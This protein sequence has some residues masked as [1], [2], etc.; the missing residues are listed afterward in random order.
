MA[1]EAVQKGFASDGNGIVIWVPAIADPAAPTLVEINAVTS[2]RLTYG[3][4]PDGFQHTITENAI[5]SGR[6]TLRQV[7]ELAG[8]VQDNLEL[9]YVY[10]R[11][12]PTDAETALGTP[13]TAGFIVH[14][15]GYENGHT[16]AAADKINAVIPCETGISRDNP[17]TANTEPSKTVKMY[18]TGEVAREVAIAA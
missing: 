12:T 17:P 3:L 6:Y 5:T 11:Q 13:G 4:T 16:L 8:T 18:V 14:I 2:K 15:L 10:N 9:T 7:I 1:T